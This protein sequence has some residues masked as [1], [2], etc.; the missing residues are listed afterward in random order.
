MT[1]QEIRNDERERCRKIIE[2]YS[3]T[4]VNKWI[5]LTGDSAKAEGWAILVAAAELRAVAP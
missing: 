1:E 5:N 4:Y 2:E 3:L